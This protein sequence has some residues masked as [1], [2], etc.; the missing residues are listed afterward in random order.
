MDFEAVPDLVGPFLQLPPISKVPFGQFQDYFLLWVPYL[1]S[2]PD[3]VRQQIFL[4][5]LLNVNPLWATII[6][7]VER[8]SFGLFGAFE[9][10]APLRLKRYNLQWWDFYCASPG[11]FPGPTQL[12]YS[13]ATTI[14]I[15]LSVDF[16][17]FTYPEE[18]R[19]THRASEVTTTEPILQT[20]KAQQKQ[21]HPKSLRGVSRGQCY[22]WAIDFF[23]GII[24]KL[25]QRSCCGEQ[26]ALSRNP[27]RK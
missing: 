18:S 4:S 22:V 10:Q 24:L 17:E 12:G 25:T 8:L 26:R 21:T 27:H 11:F 19:R 6:L 15:S 5:P 23:S 16:T 2:W 9:L 13:P 3:F 20:Q 7:D 1:W 14:S